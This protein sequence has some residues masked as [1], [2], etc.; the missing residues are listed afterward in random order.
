M[1]SGYIERPAHDEVVGSGLVAISDACAFL[2]GV[3]RAF[4]YSEMER[5]HL[6]FVKIGRRR[7]VPRK[8]LVKYAA[9]RLH[10]TYEL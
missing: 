8:A 6:P 9:A 10:G 1:K 4:L 5:G 3:S 7:M 2:G